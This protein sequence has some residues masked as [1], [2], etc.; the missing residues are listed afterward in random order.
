[1]R[2]QVLASWPCSRVGI[3]YAPLEQD[4]LLFK[5]EVLEVACLHPWRSSHWRLPPQSQVPSALGCTAILWAPGRSLAKIALVSMSVDC[6]TLKG[7]GHASFRH[8][9]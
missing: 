5:P 3:P 2:I 9:F 4:Q 8:E 7:K 1:M 6:E